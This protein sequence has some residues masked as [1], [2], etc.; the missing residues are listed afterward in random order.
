MVTDSLTGNVLT[1]MM[2]AQASG[3]SI[4]TAG[5]G[6]GPVSYTHLTRP[7]AFAPQLR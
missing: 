2:S 7:Q 6:Y 3:G 4:E 1:K 5:D